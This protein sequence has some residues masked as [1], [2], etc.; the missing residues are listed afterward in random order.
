MTRAEYGVVADSRGHEHQFNNRWPT[1]SASTP[2]P[3]YSHHAVIVGT[4]VLLVAIAVFT[5][6]VVVLLWGRR[7]R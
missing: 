7:G 1:V 6:V 2:L 4:T 3:Q 5:I